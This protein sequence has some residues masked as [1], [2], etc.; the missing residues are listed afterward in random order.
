MKNIFLILSL[1]FKRF[2]KKLSKFQELFQEN[3]VL[4]WDFWFT[5]LQRSMQVLSEHN[6][7]FAL[8]THV[9]VHNCWNDLLYTFWEI[10]FKTHAHMLKF[11]ASHIWATNSE[12][13]TKVSNF[14]KMSNLSKYKFPSEKIISPN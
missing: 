1:E 2:F 9:E 5:T 6:C 10:K 8:W 7:K 3:A 4:I 12:R 13:I 14:V 11:L